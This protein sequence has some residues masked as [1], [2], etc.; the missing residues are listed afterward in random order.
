[1]IYF[2]NSKICSQKFSCPFFLKVNKKLTKIFLSSFTKTFLIFF[3]SSIFFSCATSKSEYSKDK[4]PSYNSETHFQDG[5]PI[6]YSENYFSDKDTILLTFGGDIM[7]HKPNFNMKNYDLIYEDISSIL[8][9]S[10]LAFANIE[11][12]VDNELPNESYPTF[13][14]K[15][16]YADAVI[17]SGFNVFSL[18]NN[19]SND[20]GLEGIKATLKYFS[21]KEDSVKNSSRKIYSC[22]LKNK[23]GSPL[24]YRIINVKGWK[25]LFASVTEILNR[26][27]FSFYIDYVKT[28]EKSRA[29]FISTIKKLRVENKCD[30][31]IL[32]MHCSEPEYVQSIDENQREYYYK[33]LDAG[34]DVVWAN[35][36]HVAKNW[37]VVEKKD[38][39]VP[40]KMVMYA[41]GNTISA[42]RWE[43][44]FTNAAKQR[45]YTGDGYLL[46]VRFEKTS[47]KPK[48][49]W[50]NPVL[51]TTYITPSWNFVIKRLNDNFIK[52]LKTS[53]RNTWASYLEERK[54]L[55]EKTKGNIVCR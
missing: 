44:S 21:S 48:I 6:V 49:V 29:A 2:T 18:S 39:N 36:P 4:T 23:K 9:S 40:E 50:V 43:P 55:M 12:P 33:L 41:L 26:N 54:N 24:T 47:S 13:N 35:H 11:T 25:I 15:D 7:A 31:F 28:D 14:V 16:S 42:Q 10:D 51:I 27:D 8:K 1:M 3:L 46:Q 34:V 17:K 45:E 19:H 38:L 37:E 20:Q 52:E 30:L 22:G 32:G 5:S 53:K